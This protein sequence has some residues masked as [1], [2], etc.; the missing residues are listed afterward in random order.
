MIQNE[1]LIVQRQ[2]SRQ[3]DLGR[4]LRHEAV[5]SFE[6]YFFV[7]RIIFI[8]VKLLY[9]RHLQFLKKVSAIKEVSAI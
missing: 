2:F 5:V 7:F 1:V 8:T 4:V 6:K 9:S 3:I